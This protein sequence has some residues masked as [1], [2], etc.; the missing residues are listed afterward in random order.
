M[1]KYFTIS[2]ALMT[3]LG[4]QSCSELEPVMNIDHN[5][6]LPMLFLLTYLLIGIVIIYRG[7][8]LYAKRLGRSQVN[9]VLIGVFF[10]PLM[11]IIGL[12]LWGE[13]EVQRG[14]NHTGL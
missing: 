1:K 12:W 6:P 11:A 8:A 7:I 5:G 14:T 13:C 9:W 2:T 10:S 4:L 3:L